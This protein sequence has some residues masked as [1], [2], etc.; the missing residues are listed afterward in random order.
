MEFTLKVSNFA[1]R[2]CIIAKVMPDNRVDTLH[3]HINI[4]KDIWQNSLLLK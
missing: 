1:V 3:L 4:Y 2:N